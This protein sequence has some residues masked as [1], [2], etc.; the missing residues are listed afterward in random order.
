MVE[1]QPTKGNLALRNNAPRVIVINPAKKPESI[2]LRVA[3]YARVS[4][5]SEDQLNS[6]A[7]QNRYYTKLISEQENWSLV[8]VYADKGITG[9]SAEKRGDFQRLMS[10]CRRGLIDRVLVKSISRFARNTKE[11]LEAVRELKTLGVSVCFEKEHIDTG[12]MSGEMVAALFATFAQAE[13]QSISSNMRWSYQKR[14]QSGTFVPSRQPFGYRLVEKKIV[15]DLPKA[16]FVCEIFSLYLSGWNTREIAEYLNSLQPDHPELCDRVWSVAAVSRILKNEKYIGDSLWQKTYQTDT[17]PPKE[18]PNRGERNQYY[19]AETHPAI[20]DKKCYAAAQHLLAKRNL[21]RKSPAL[22]LQNP[23]YCVVICGHCGSYLREKSVRGYVYRTCRTH[24]ITR[25]QCPMTPV[26]EKELKKAFLCLYYN[27]KHYGGPILSE[28][29]TSLQTIRSWR[30]LWSLD[31]VELNKRISELSSQNQMLAAL[32]QQGLIDPDI[33]ISQS[34]EL[35]KQLRAAK[36]DKER[37]LV[38]DSDTTIERTQELM[39]ILEAGPDFLDH[40]DGELFSE[41]IDKIIVD[42]NERVR[43]RLKNGLELTE[44]IERM[45]R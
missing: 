11:C 10:D 13:S 36:L 32:K 3:A 14:M 34:N 18:C 5:A 27:L 19:V 8:D 29:I 4:S 37:L 45:V 22:S 28:M 7:A 23:L 39:D 9:T 43:F 20:I 24:D 30:M 33:F 31:I 40:F 16:K 1:K 38:A 26:P 21:T 41:L 35:T 12:T 44:T 17:F 42:S 25:E 15:V 6:F 2:K